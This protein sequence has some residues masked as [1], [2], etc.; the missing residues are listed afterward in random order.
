MD[1]SDRATVERGVKFAPFT[2]WNDRP[3]GEAER[4][5][6]LAD[7]HGVGREHLAQHCDRWSVGGSAFWR[8]NRASFDF[9]ASVI[10]HCA[11]KNV[12]GFCVGGNAKTW[13]VNADDA[14]TVDL[15]WKKA[16]RDTRCCWDAQVG[17]NHCIVTV[18]VSEVV[19][20]FAY[21]FEQFAGDKRFGVE[22]Y[23]ADGAACPVEVRH[24]RQAINTAGRAR[25]NG[26]RPAHA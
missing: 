13:H 12:F 17:D 14:Y 8:L 10:Q 2:R 20:G 24:E 19:D 5:E 11:C 26:R 9:L 25:Q 3:G 7:D 22:G 1:R 4:F 6:H 21:V 23:I 18:G 16:Q 15:I